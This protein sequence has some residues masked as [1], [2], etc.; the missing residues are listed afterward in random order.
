MFDIDAD[1]LVNTVN[2]VGVMGKGVAL[3]FKQRYPEMFDRY[4]DH[5]KKNYIYPGGVCIYKTNDD[6]KILNFAT[7]NHWENPSK[8]EYITKGLKTLKIM[9]KQ[10]KM[11]TVVSM[12]ALGCGHGGLNWNIVWEMIKDQLGNLDN[13]VIYIFQPQDSR[14]IGE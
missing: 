8:Y 2:C 10:Q 5:C 13:V 7:K 11:G 1:V 9:L 4:K 6:K 12:P 3:A 14:Q